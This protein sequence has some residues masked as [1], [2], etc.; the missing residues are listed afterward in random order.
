MRFYA[1]V[2]EQLYRDRRGCF[3]TR[4]RSSQAIV[5]IHHEGEEPTFMVGLRQRSETVSDDSLEVTQWVKNRII[6]L[7]GLCFLLV[8]LAT[9]SQQ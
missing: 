7:P 3:K 6:S 2:N 5:A 8:T 9:I 4:E 1:V